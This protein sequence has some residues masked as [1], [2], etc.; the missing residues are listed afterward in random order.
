MEFRLLVHAAV[1]AKIRG[2]EE[3]LQMYLSDRK[4]DFH[5]MV[6]RMTG[7]D[8]DDSKTIN[9]GLVFGMGEAH[10]SRS[11]N[12]TREESDE[13][14]AT[15]HRKVPFVKGTFDLASRTASH[16]HVILT[17]L[18]RQARFPGG[19][20][21]HAALNRYTQGSCADIMKLAMVDTWEAG[22][23]DVLGAPLLTVHDEL[24]WSAPCTDEANEALMECQHIMENCFTLKVPL[25]AEME[26]GMDWANCKPATKEDL[27]D[28]S[29]WV[30]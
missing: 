20:F 17:L 26:M 15:Y 23:C 3:A 28:R 22:L 16:R 8:R 13:I 27:W 5:E 18:K 2:A 25:I 1:I 29:Q 9:F 19:E 6:V 14:M 11:L 30:S 24:D 12:K 10:L 7:L 4:T 21:T